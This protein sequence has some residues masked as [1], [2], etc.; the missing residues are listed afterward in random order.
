[1]KSSVIAVLM[2]GACALAQA[3]EEKKNDFLGPDEWPVTVEAAVD[4]MLV[5]L[6]ADFRARV[7]GK[8]PQDLVL[9]MG[10]PMWVRNH[11]GLWR[12]NRALAEDACGQP[13]HP[14]NASGLIIK[15][16]LEKLSEQPAPQP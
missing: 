2:A 15:R 7:H 1:M 4:D 14:D 5:R 10:F 6:P 11:Y 8:K 16:F 13:C 9:Y 12:G 3:A